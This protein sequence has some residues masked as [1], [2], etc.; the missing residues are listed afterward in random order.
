[1]SESVNVIQVF[2][3]LS[4]VLM[5]VVVVAVLIRANA[6]ENLLETIHLQLNSKMDALLHETGRA[7]R[8]AG[9]EQER[10]AER[11]RQSEKQEE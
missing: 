4:F 8:A 7:E 9:V 10:V 3:V 6:I 1:M 2:S 5:F 11:A